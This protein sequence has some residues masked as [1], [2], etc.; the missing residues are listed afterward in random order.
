MN[1]KYFIILL[2][3]LLAACLPQIVLGQN[4]GTVYKWVDE[5]GKLHYSQSLPPDYKDLAH[6]KMNDTGTVVSRINRTLTPEE[7]KALRAQEAIARQQRI[8]EETREKKDR[9]LL[10][11]YRSEEDIRS[12][13]EGELSV[14]TEQ[15]DLIGKSIND[16]LSSLR[17]LV[18]QAAD[19][20]R[21]GQPVPEIV[22]N[23]IQSIQS[24]VRRQRN[25]LARLT[26]QIDFSRANY[27]QDLA[28][29]RDLSG[30]PPAAQSQS[31]DNPASDG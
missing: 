19:F 3:I 5:N 7:R 15:R 11:A 28:R 2:A 6:E 10:A 29:Y 18:A 8:S 9:L 1:T 22:S 14:L 13:M 12:V 16:Q 27:E 24:V 23:P 21:T 17:D 25:N 4:Q 20:E 30:S 26:E 31:S